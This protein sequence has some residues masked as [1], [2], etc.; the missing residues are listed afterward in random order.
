MYYVLWNDWI[1]LT[2]IK[3][4]PSSIEDPTEE[5]FDTPDCPPSLDDDLVS[6]NDTVVSPVCDHACSTPNT[7]PSR[8][9]MKIS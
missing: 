1:S 4:E 8:S 6:I 5:R 7:I 2:I 3:D 9:F